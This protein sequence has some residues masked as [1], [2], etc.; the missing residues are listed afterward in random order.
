MMRRAMIN[1]RK[2]ILLVSKSEVEFGD[3][4]SVGLISNDQVHM[5][6]VMSRIS[7]G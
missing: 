5:L 7:D 4:K 6:C 3:Q 2:S 1:L